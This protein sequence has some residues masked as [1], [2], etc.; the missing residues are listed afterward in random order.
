[1]IVKF[2]IHLACSN[3][4]RFQSNQEVLHI[5]VWNWLPASENVKEVKEKLKKLNDIK[6]SKG[7]SCHMAIL[8]KK[9]E[10]LCLKFRVASVCR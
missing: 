3:D 10:I 2:F 7:M 4:D 8:P 6:D 9:S 1:M 5:D